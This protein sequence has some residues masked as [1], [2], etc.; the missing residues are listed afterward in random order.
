MSLKAIGTIEIPKAAGSSF[1]HGAFEPKTRRIF[2]AHTG[3]DSV[4]VIDHDSGR[5]IATLA[6]FPEAAGVVADGGQVLVTNRGAAKVA[7]LDARTLDTKAVFET[8]ENPN[9]VAIVAERSLAIVASIGD[10]G[11][12]AKLEVFNRDGRLGAI[13]LPG[14]PRW[15]VT[16]AAAERVFLAIR[17]PSMVLVAQLPD[18]IG[19]AHWKL[20]VGGAHGLDIDHLG[21]RL[22]AAV[23]TVP[24]SKSTSHPAPQAVGGRSLAPRT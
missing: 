24:W 22:Y 15:C 5:H 10:D 9:G 13:D 14:R 3:R 18:L 17:D 1:D 19:V 11:R 7:W 2:V 8:G 12:G 23:T 20:P 4:E 6:G 21:G 16:D